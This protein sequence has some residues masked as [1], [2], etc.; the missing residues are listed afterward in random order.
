M[1]TKTDYLSS[2]LRKLSILVFDDNATFEYIE[3]ISSEFLSFETCR[4]FSDLAQYLEDVSSGSKGRADIVALDLFCDDYTTFELL[5]FD[6]AVDPATCGLQLLQHVLPK[7][8]ENIDDVPALIFSSY[9]EKVKD[10]RTEKVARQRKA[11]LKVCDREDFSGNL[12]N[13]IVEGGLWSRE[14]VEAHLPRDLNQ[15]EFY[16]LFLV[17][18]EEFGL[19]ESE[20][21]RIL[22]T[23]DDDVSVS[24]VFQTTKMAN[25]RVEILMKI[26][27]G[28]DQF[29]STEGKRQYL[30]AT[31]LNWRGYSCMDSILEEPT[32]GLP[33]VLRKIEHA[34]GGK[35]F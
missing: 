28:L 18:A 26:T 1:T 12:K 7:Y 5:G 11:Q 32:E 6:M 31:E 24:T 3:E 21:K 25:A 20:Q 30:E 34:L 10:L 33:R 15:Y 4:S 19:S 2:P 27:V 14:C 9:P 35:V 29:L 16:D 8:I 17:L 13:L 23:V 22:E